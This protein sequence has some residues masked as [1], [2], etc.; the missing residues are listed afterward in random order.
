MVN[1]SGGMPDE[2]LVFKV[3]CAVGLFFVMQLGFFWTKLENLD[4]KKL[5]V[6]AEIAMLS[7][8]RDELNKKIWML[9]K[10]VYRLETTL[11]RIDVTYVLRKL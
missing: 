6:E 3:I 11:Q 4:D 1:I 2:G 10:D 5:T 9:E 8:K 7:R